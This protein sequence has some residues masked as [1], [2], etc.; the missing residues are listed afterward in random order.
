MSS[1]DAAISVQHIS[2]F[3][4]RYEKPSHRLLQMLYHGRK[5]F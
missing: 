4:E 2:K 1:E 3:F 5:P